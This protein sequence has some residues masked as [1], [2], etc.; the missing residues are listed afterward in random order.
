MHMFFNLGS[1]INMENKK[2]EFS[3]DYKQ[4]IVVTYEGLIKQVNKSGFIMLNYFDFNKK[5]INS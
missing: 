2:K 5:T 4:M 1:D 3:I